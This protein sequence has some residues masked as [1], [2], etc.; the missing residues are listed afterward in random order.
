MAL[1]FGTLRAGDDA[2]LQLWLDLLGAVFSPKAERS[3]FAAKHTHDTKSSRRARNVFVA[4]DGGATVGS[5]RLYERR[6]HVGGAGAAAGGLGEVATRADYRGRGVASAL[7]ALAEAAA[8]RLEFGGVLHTSSAAA[9]YQRRGWRQVDAVSALLPIRAAD[10]DVAGAEPGDKY[11]RRLQL[12]TDD[13]AAS[14]AV[15]GCYG[16]CA[17]GFDGTA[18]REAVYWPW[19]CAEARRRGCRG[20]ELAGADGGAAAYALFACTSWERRDGNLPASTPGPELVLCDFGCS[21]DEP[22]EAA[23]AVELLASACLR[24]GP[25]GAARCLVPAPLLGPLANDLPRRTD[26]GWHFLCADG[27]LPDS[28]SLVV[29]P[30]DRF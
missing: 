27:A 10:D 16:A 1:C 3:Y 29:W 24:D 28:S 21:S 4:R 6:V 22:A 25:G 7:L 9:L 12:A 26:P 8:R 20:Y 17:A 5:V 14:A 15:R 23:V 13:W 19:V 30:V 18:K 11:V 2:D